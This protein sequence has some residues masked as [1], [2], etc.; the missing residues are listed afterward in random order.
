MYS[1]G[2]LW[3]CRPLA[4]VLGQKRKLAR[5]SQEQWASKEG[6]PAASKQ[7]S[8][9]L[10]IRHMPAQRTIRRLLFL[11][12]KWRSCSYKKLGKSIII[13]KNSLGIMRCQRQV[14][15]LAQPRSNSSK[16]HTDHAHWNTRGESDNKVGK[17]LNQDNKNM[18]TS[19][20]TWY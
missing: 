11:K 7:A 12:T 2:S 20:H 10:L 16:R 9:V 15:V 14:T 17:N 18:L 1:T 6:R 13:P 3:F 19:K 8:V 4:P 5:R